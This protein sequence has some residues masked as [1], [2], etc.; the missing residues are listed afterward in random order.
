MLALEYKRWRSRQNS[1]ATAA[2]VSIEKL[3][4][5]VF[6]LMIAERL[7]S[8]L[9]LIDDVRGGGPE[10]DSMGA[11][12]MVELYNG[13][14][15]TA[16]H[17]NC[18]DQQSFLDPNQAYDGNVTISCHTFGYRAP[19]QLLGAQRME[20]AQYGSE[21][22]KPF[23]LVI[24]VLSNNITMRKAIRETWGAPLREKRELVFLIANQDFDSIADEY[25][26]EKDILWLDMEN[27]Y[28]KL[29]YMTSAMLTILHRHTPYSH[30]LKTD[31]DCYIHADR[32]AKHIQQQ[33]SSI[34]Y[35]GHI[36]QLLAPIRHK[37]EVRPKYY[38]YILP[39]EVYPEPSFAPYA[40]GPGYIVTPTMNEC[41]VRELSRIRYMPFEDVYVGLLA[42]RCG[43]E[44]YG[45]N[46]F[47][48]DLESRWKF[49]AEGQGSTDEIVVQHKMT[50]T[51]DL[52]YEYPKNPRKSFFH[53]S[54]RTGASATCEVPH[55]TPEI[56]PEFAYRTAVVSCKP[57]LYKAPMEKLNQTQPDDLVFLVT[58]STNSRQRAAVRKSWASQAG[59]NHVYFVV[60]SPKMITFKPEFKEF[61]DLIWV[62]AA[63]DERPLYAI[64]AAMQA[65]QKRAN[66]RYLVFV[67]FKTYLYPNRLNE[68]LTGDFFGSCGEHPRRIKEE[69]RQ[70]R[71][72]QLSTE[73]YPEPY[74]PPECS[75][76]GYAMSSSLVECAAVE[77]QQI[78]FHPVESI[79]MGNLALRC[80]AWA[81]NAQHTFLKG[82]KRAKRSDIGQI[83]SDIL[84]VPNVMKQMMTGTMG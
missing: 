49:E 62:Q 14:G 59:K 68:I 8:L 50:D 29:T 46:L 41:V 31:D 32:L 33:N 26:S 21:P 60:Q 67:N 23:R 52:M 15:A 25:E 82:A 7:Q 17:A 37:S 40:A 6:L 35:Y 2:A 22:H 43:F 66:F 1:Q 53:Q 9:R 57:L 48:G 42:E 34:H 44:C 39:P 63:K 13:E 4:R 28:Y 51:S 19:I 47:V 16:A 5:I 64:Q 73:L 83:S 38:K 45:S 80:G 56:A 81:T 70:V 74:L 27:N 65:I 76:A 3:L 78:R 20:P 79:A 71:S 61:R 30:I 10:L 55:D 54:D 12:P 77:S 69:H 24:G 58:G 18:T 84:M 11:M 75:H 36:P 72:R